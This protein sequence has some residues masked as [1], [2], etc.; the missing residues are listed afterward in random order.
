MSFYILVD[1]PQVP[2]YLRYCSFPYM[3][4]NKIVLLIA[5]LVRENWMVTPALTCLFYFPP[6]SLFRKCL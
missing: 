1:F 4:D 6:L 5:I 2:L 3:S